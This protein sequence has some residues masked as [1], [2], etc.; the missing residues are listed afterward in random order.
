MFFSS[1]SKA[2]T[3]LVLSLFVTVSCSRSHD[4]SSVSHTAEHSMDSLVTAEWLHANLDDPDLVVLDASV[5]IESDGNGGFRA[6]NGRPAYEEGHIPT[7]GFADLQGALADT[8]S[9]HG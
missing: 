5:T 1:A 9:P 6:I 3:A 4:P 7:A 2:I 8:S